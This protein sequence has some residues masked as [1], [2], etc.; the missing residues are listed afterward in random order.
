MARLSKEVPE[1]FREAGLKVAETPAGS[2]KVPSVMAESN[3]FCSISVAEP[4]APPP[5][6]P[7]R[8]EL[9]NARPKFW[10]DRL[11]PAVRV[12]LPEVAMMVSGYVAAIAAAPGVTVSVV[13]PP[14]VKDEG[15][16]TPVASAGN[17][18]TLKLTLPEKPV[19][20][21]RFTTHEVL[22]AAVKDRKAGV[23]DIEISLV[24]I[25]VT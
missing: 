14:D 7:L 10:I 9:V 13:I 19:A 8:V 4:V 11:T 12:T 16:N 2:P 23:A 24:T 20:V 21:V 3:P 1:V 15:L 18:V 17:P 25:A 5:A 6:A 22:D